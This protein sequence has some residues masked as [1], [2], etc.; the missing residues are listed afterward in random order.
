M[1]FD[2]L[3]GKKAAALY[4]Q[5][6][7]YQKTARFYY[8]KAEDTYYQVITDYIFTISNREVALC[9]NFLPKLIVRRALNI[10]LTQFRHFL[11]QSV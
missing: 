5:A 4:T 1:Q 8:K 9:T 6:G 7:D 3:Y 2:T 11:L 10:A